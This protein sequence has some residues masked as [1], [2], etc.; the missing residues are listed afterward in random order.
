MEWDVLTSFI[1][2]IMPDFKIEIAGSHE[3][4]QTPC[5]SCRG[6][7]ARTHIL[8]IPVDYCKLH[9]HGVWFDKDELRQI[10][11]RVAVPSDAP[12]EAPTSFTSLL[13]DFFN[14]RTS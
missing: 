8:T 13:N 14:Q 12:P 7:M 4:R 11:E 2:N 3:E 9:N 10:L 6:S 1:N 5:P